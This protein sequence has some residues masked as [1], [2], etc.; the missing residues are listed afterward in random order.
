MRQILGKR[1]ELEMILGSNYSGVLSSDDY[2]VYNGYNVKAQQK[3][4]AHLRRHF[5]KLMKLPGLNN[6]KIGETFVKLID[7][8]FK[9]AREL[10]A[11]TKFS[12]FLKLGF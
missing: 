10:P 7:E 3:C 5:K 6:L 9:P 12:R 11:R 4:L 8:A 2:S 1:A